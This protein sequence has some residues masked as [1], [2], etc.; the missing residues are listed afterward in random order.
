MMTPDE[1]VVQIIRVATELVLLGYGLYVT[2]RNKDKTKVLDAAEEKVKRQ[3]IE[4]VLHEER[5]EELQA[6]VA[7]LEGQ[8]VFHRE[9]QERKKQQTDSRRERKAKREKELKTLLGPKV[10]DKD[11]EKLVSESGES[12]RN[13]TKLIERFR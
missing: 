1:I 4:I 5:I 6:E 12:G 13:I 7:D 9:Q 8:V 3:R 10:T 11:I 2:F